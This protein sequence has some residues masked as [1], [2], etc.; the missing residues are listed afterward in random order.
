MDKQLMNRIHNATNPCQGDFKKVLC[1]CSAGLLRS[2]TAAWV[3]SNPPFNYNT[4]ACGAV[5][6][7]ALIP[8]DEVLIRWADEI[9]CMEEEH[10]ETVLHELSQMEM[11][12]RPEV[13]CLYI[14]DSYYYRQKELQWLI[15]E[16]Y[17]AQ[18]EIWK[19][20]GVETIVNGSVTV[21]CGQGPVTNYTTYKPHDKP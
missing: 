6:A 18:T 8:L 1:V 13:K 11:A 9:V 5:R 21:S 16:K 7:F 17:K 2:P 4:R 14:E 10:Y 12:K 15:A 19:D 20:E 3:L